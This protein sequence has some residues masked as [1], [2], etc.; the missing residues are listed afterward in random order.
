M[1]TYTFQ[2]I[3]QKCGQQFDEYHCVYGQEYGTCPE[4]G[5]S[6]KRLFLPAQVII[7]G[8]ICGWA[9]FNDSSAA[10][11]EPP[12]DHKEFGSKSYAMSAAKRNTRGLR[13]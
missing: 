10:D 11:V 7:G 2:C 5:M 4:C 1:P 9:A 3:N 12:R 8:P 13:F 6:G